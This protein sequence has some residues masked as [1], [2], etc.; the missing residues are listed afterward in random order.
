MNRIG[1]QFKVRKDK[2]EAYKRIHQDV[3]S[4]M[5]QALRDSE[6]HNYSLFMREDGLVFG[7]FES[8]HSLAEAQAKM[9]E[10]E[11]NL[12]WQNFMSSFME[13]GARPDES[14][15]ELEEYFHLD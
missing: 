3:W 4:E 8:E 14:F 5:L 10:K 9:E 2:I 1:F 11:I 13:Q 12:R 15:I 7:Y 6:W